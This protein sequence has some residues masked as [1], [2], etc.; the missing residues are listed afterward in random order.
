MLV[1]EYLHYLHG[2]S[3]D[4]RG[5]NFFKFS[6]NLTQPLSAFQGIASI[7]TTAIVDSMKKYD[8]LV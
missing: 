4:Y 6:I 5:G 8:I 1:Q 2:I 3:E 7:G